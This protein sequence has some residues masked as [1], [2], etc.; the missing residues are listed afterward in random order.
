MR[1]TAQDG[2]SDERG[3]ARLCLRMESADFNP[4]HGKGGLFAKS[5]GG[6]GGGGSSSG[7]SSGKNT[8]GEG[9]KKSEGS[10]TG[11]NAKMQ[12]NIGTLTP[13]QQKRAHEMSKAISS[14]KAT[15]RESGMQAHV[16]GTAEYRKH[17]KEMELQGRKASTFE[18]DY[19]EFVPEIMAALKNRTAHYTPLKTGGIHAKID[20]GRTTGTTHGED[21]KSTHKTT[22]VTAVHSEKENDWHF[23]P[24]DPD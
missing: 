16:P 15:L 20:L 19:H 24:D 2:Q 4:N 5:A 8:G 10:N 17:A 6:G 21:G 14:G 7:S 23:Y 12:P 3:I 13:K 9:E 22:V 18:G 11:G 1:Q